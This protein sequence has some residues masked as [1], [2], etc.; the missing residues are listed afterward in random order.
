M[1]TIDVNFSPIK[2]KSLPVLRPEYK[3]YAPSK[4]EVD[5]SLWELK[6]PKREEDWYLGEDKEI[7]RINARN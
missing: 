7:A 3:P 4:I 1:P 2:L 5:E 6:G